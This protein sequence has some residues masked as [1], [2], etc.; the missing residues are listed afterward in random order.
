MWA[1]HLFKALFPEKHTCSNAQSQPPVVSR[2]ERCPHFRGELMHDPIALGLY[3]GV[4]IMGEV[5]A[6]QESTLGVLL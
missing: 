5:F 2:L 6:F 3:E 4:R 1:D